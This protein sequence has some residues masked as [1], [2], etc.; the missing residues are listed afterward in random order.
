MHSDLKCKQISYASLPLAYLVYIFYK[1][2]KYALTM[3]WHGY[4]YFSF[5]ARPLRLM[6]NFATGKE[7][8]DSSSGL[9][10]LIVTGDMFCV[11]F[12]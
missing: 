10:F 7:A 9:Y 1:A 12:I 11:H 8:G 6:K 2:Q 4:P 3:A 5:Q